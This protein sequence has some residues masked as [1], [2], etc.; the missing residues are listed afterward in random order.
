MFLSGLCTRARVCT[1]APL[2]PRIVKKK[3]IISVIKKDES[4]QSVLL[5]YSCLSVCFN[6]SFMEAGVN[7]W[8]L[9]SSNRFTKWKK[10]SGCICK[11]RGKH[12]SGW[13]PA[14]GVNVWLHTEQG[15]WASSH[16]LVLICPDPTCFL[17]FWEG[18]CEVNDSYLFKGYHATQFS[19]QQNILPGPRFWRI[20]K[21]GR[22]KWLHNILRPGERSG[23]AVVSRST[24][25]WTIPTLLFWTLQSQQVCGVGR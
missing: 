10:K 18:S 20:L 24:R 21:R 19:H 12:G 6:N 23:P 17:G 2:P 8:I 7:T 5:L 16:C 4:F 25:N 22:R 14:T 3:R 13:L 15:F 11:L 9:R 1:L